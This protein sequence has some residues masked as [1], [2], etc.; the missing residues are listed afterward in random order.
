MYDHFGAWDFHLNKLGNVP[1]GNVVYKIAL[2][3]AKHLSQVILKKI[4]EYFTMYF[5][6]SNPELPGSEPF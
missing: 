4:F 5:Y 2:P 1:L 3:N 6:G